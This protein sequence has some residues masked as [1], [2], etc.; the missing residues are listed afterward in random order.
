MLEINVNLQFL[1]HND[2]FLFKPILQPF[3]VIIA[4]VKVQS[5]SNKNTL[6]IH[7]IKQSKDYVV[8]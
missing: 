7:L 5:I 2:F 3:S 4:T 8:Q 1:A 6:I